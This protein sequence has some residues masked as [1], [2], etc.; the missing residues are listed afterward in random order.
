MAR[1]T[2]RKNRNY[3]KKDKKKEYKILNLT[4]YTIIL[5]NEK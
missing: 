1:K 2:K 3:S 4:P 5:V